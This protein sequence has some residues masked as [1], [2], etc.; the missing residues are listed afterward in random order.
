[1]LVGQKLVVKEREANRRL[2]E[3]RTRNH[4]VIAIR[5]AV[6][7]VSVQLDLPAMAASEDLE[8]ALDRNLKVVSENEEN[9]RARQ[10]TKKDAAEL[11]R[12]RHELLS[13]RSD[14][15]IKLLEKEGRLQRLRTGRDIADEKIKQARE[16]VRRVNEAKGDIVRRVFGESLNSIWH[17]L[18]MRLAPDEPFV[19]AFA[20]PHVQSRSVEAVLETLYRSGGRGGIQ[21]R[22]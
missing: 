10:S 17:D 2:N 1:M 13:Q 18:F 3:Y 8:G 6:R 7:K 22:C 16:L 12:K 15:S 5:D 19:P 9:L 11:L 14:R 20:V 21:E 4:R